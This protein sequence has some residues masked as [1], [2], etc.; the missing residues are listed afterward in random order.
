MQ[1]LLALG[2]RSHRQYVAAA[3][4]CRWC[5]KRRLMIPNRTRM[6]LILGVGLILLIAGIYWRV[7]ATTRDGRGYWKQETKAVMRQTCR[8]LLQY[9][10]ET[11][12]WPT[13]LSL[14]T[15]NGA[16]RF[17]YIETSAGVIQDGWRRPLVFIP[18][19]P[20]RGF[21]VLRSLGQDGALG[22]RGS[23]ADIEFWFSDRGYSEHQPRPGANR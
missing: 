16:G 12:S 3:D 9:H 4:P 17:C 10:Q 11:A 13:N 7:M 2:S 1:P 8:A 19:E 5:T 23:D 22:G 21:G 14:L 6:V 20:S 15:S 18:Y